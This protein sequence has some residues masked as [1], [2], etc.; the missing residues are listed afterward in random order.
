M[1]N[2]I[3]C[4]LV[5]TRNQDE[6]ES[7]QQGGAAQPTMADL[8]AAVLTRQQGDSEMLRQLVENTSRLGGHGGNRNNNNQP[9]QCTYLNF[10]VP[11]RRH[12]S[13]PESLWTRITGCVRP[14]LNSVC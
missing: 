6:P 12:S 5:R 9:R 3:N 2:G 1:C 8:I 13:V 10:W 4:S 7:S 14:S 11:I